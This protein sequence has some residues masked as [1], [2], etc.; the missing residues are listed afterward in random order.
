MNNIDADQ[1]REIVKMMPIPAVEFVI[2]RNGQFLLG[3]R[4]HRP[5]KGSWWFPGGRITKGETLAEAITRKLHEETNLSA[6][7]TALLTVKE[8]SF[9]DSQFDVPTQTINIIYR[10]EVDD[11]SS[12]RGDEQH[13]ELQ[14]FSQIDPNWDPYVQG[15][16][17]FAGFK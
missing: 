2:V 7:H 9:P 12:V 4:T 13:S 3:K 14:W 5:V 6:K 10:I 8:I 16:L 17:R 11:D 15:V 1:Y